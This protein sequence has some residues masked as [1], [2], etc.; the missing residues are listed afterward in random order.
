MGKILRYDRNAGKNTDVVEV[1]KNHTKKSGTK[2]ELKDENGQ[3]YGYYDLYDIT[4][5][6]NPYYFTKLNDSGKVEK[7]LYYE[8]EKTLKDVRGYYY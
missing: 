4:I 3:V 2:T 7:S 1:V 6:T 8:S 5:G